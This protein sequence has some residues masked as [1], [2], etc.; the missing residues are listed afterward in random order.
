MHRNG[1]VV[2]VAENECPRDEAPA[3][4]FSARLSLPGY[5]MGFSGQHA[6]DMKGAGLALRTFRNRLQT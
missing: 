5:L 3:G 6:G 4:E 1:L 2:L